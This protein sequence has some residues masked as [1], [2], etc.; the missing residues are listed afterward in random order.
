[1]AEIDELKKYATKREFEILEAIH[2]CGGYR[3]A[4]RELNTHDSNVSR[5]MNRLRFRAAQRGHAPEYDLTHPVPPAYTVK[6]H[7]TL[8]D[9]DGNMRLQWIKSNADQKM[10]EQ[11]MREAMDAFCDELPRAKPVQIT[12]TSKLEDLLNLIPIFDYHLGMYSWHEETG[13]DWDTAIAENL[14]VD[15]ILAGV[16]MAPDAKTAILLQGGDFMHWD[17]MD[18]VTPAS[19]H[20][21]DAD[22]RF[23][24]L[25]RV[26]IRVLMRITNELLKKHDSVHVIM[27]EGNHDPASSIWL[28]EWFAAWFEDEPRVTVDQSPD[29]YY[30]YEFGKTSIFVHHGHKKGVKSLDDVFAAKFR[31]VFGRTKYSYG[32]MGHLHHKHVVESNLMI[33]EQHPTL[34]APDAYAS[35]GGMLSKRSASVITYHKEYGEVGRI[36]ITPEM[37]E[38]RNA[39]TGTT[40]KAKK[41]QKRVRAASKPGKRSRSTSK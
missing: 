13:A 14:L 21:L 35:R 38:A 7:S 34:A 19:K 27:A 17:G 32:H 31:E 41:S 15:W 39:E 2:R 12:K 40:G 24:K 22:T 20:L 1:M 36:T 6:G 18:A 23:A 37:L 26:A 29:P 8:Y 25:V 33:V 28:R 10:A 9:A 5:A 4:A 30:C 11:M 3:A 16:R